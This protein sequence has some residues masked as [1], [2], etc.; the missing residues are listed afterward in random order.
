MT[1][2]W[3]SCPPSWKR[4]Q[5]IQIKPLAIFVFELKH[6]KKSFDCKYFPL[7]DYLQRVYDWSVCFGEVSVFVHFHCCRQRRLVHR[8]GCRYG[9]VGDDWSCVVLGISLGDHFDCH[10]RRHFL[11]H[12]VH[13]C[14]HLHLHW[15][16]MCNNF[17]NIFFLF[18]KKKH[19]LYLRI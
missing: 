4:D 2:F 11:H 8:P 6:T 15:L 1:V 17:T 14:H 7:P 3:T 16:R 12:F 10:H 19:S 9:Y 13:H 18:K 5:K